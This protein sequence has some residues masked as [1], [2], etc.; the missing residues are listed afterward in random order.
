MNSSGSI[1]LVFCACFV[2]LFNQTRTSRAAEQVVMSLCNGQAN[3][4][5]MTHGFGL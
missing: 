3:V 4:L 2:V 5:R 1:V